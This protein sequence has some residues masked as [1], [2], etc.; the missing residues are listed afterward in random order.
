M[1]FFTALAFLLLVHVYIH[2]V[3]INALMHFNFMNKL[4]SKLGEESHDF[5]LGFKFVKHPTM[6]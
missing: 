5:Q 2:R 1:H 6:S 3:W 4:N